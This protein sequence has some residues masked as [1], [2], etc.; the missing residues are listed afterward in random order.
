MSCCGQKRTALR[1]ESALARARQNTSS[2]PAPRVEAPQPGNTS[3]AVL[4]YL[5][6]GT[7]S[8]RGPHTGR[9]YYFAATGRATVVHEHDVDALL[10]T[11][12]FAREDP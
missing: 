8:L 5:G 12:L 9:V 4:R 10:G 11:R 1:A 7:L 3:N 2:T 6:G